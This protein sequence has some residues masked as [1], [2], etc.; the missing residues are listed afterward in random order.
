MT[1]QNQH[2]QQHD[3]D[4]DRERDQDPFPRGHR[5]L[6]LLRHSPD[7]IRDTDQG[8]QQDDD[9]AAHRQKREADQGQEQFQPGKIPVTGVKADS[10][11]NNCACMILATS[12]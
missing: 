10:K 3:H 5:L 8:I 2:G 6:F 11:N 1:E 4:H 7:Q 12:S 9:P